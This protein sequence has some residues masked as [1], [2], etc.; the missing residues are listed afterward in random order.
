MTI[1]MM[2]EYDVAN[3]MVIGR[4]NKIAMRNL[5]VFHFIPKRSHTI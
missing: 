2:I 1:M 3:G 4:G 5:P